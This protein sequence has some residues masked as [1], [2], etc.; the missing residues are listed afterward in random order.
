M[1]DEPDRPRRLEEIR[2]RAEEG[3]YSAGG[4]PPPARSGEDDLPGDS[5]TGAFD[6]PEALHEIARTLESRG[7]EAW[8]VG[9]AVR[10]AL[11]GQ[12]GEDWDLATDARP[13]DV[14]RVFRRTVPVG[15]EHG[16]VGVLGSDE[17]MY[18]VTTFRRDIRTD[19]RHAVVEFTGDIREDLG[20]RDFTINAVAWRP[21]T[22]EVLDPSGGRNDMRDRVLRAVGNP[23]E[24]FREDYLRVLRGLRFAGR[25]SLRIEEETRRALEGATGYLGDL[26]AERIRE[27]L[28]K[29]LADREP[30]VALRLYAEFGVLEEWYPE[31]VPAYVEDPRREIYLAAVDAL[32]PTRVPLR[33]ARWLVP[34]A[35]DGERRAE[36]VREITERL[37]FSNRERD[38][39]VHLVANYQ[40]LVSPTDSAAQIREWIAGV[41]RENVYDLFRLHLA[42]ARAVAA[43]EKGR[44]L[45]HLWRRVREEARK[46]PPLTLDDLAVDG[47][48]LMEVGVKQGPEVGILLEELMARVIEEPELNDRERLLE[49]AEELMEMG[50]L[51]ASRGDER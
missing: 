35:E 47:N 49:L 29:I 37:R 7:Y 4:E 15:V 28:T 32:P 22:D 34:V 14:Q 21:A 20:R 27:E 26:S 9:G 1:S 19:G 33:L 45:I 38:R 30:S 11:M 25:F 50:S 43:E 13:D 39:V 5:L 17:E 2:E 10:D 36:A 41:G 31:L 12:G 42:D 23:R 16:T 24:R 46:D 40:P 44:Y 48:D 51:S 3:T 18:E 8:A 6:P